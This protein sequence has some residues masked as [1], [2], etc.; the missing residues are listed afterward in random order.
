[1]IRDDDKCLRRQAYRRQVALNIRRTRQQ[2][3]LTQRDVAK[4]LQL[5]RPAVSEMEAG[6]RRIAVEELIAIADLLHVDPCKLLYCKPQRAYDLY[7]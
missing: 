5:H 3:N 2:K 7:E 1:M 4:H 6:R